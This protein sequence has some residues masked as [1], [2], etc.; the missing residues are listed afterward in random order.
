MLEKLLKSLGADADTISKI[1]AEKPEYDPEKVAG[2][3][4]ANLRKAM[5][6]DT[7]FIDPLRQ[8]WQGEVLSS[9]ERQLVKLSGGK[10]TQEELDALPTTDRFNKAIELLITKVKGS[11]A[12]T[13]KSIKD[14]DEEIAKL[15]SDLSERDLKIKD[16]AEVKLPAAQKE[17]E[18][19]VE[20][21]N[22]ERYVE[23]SLTKKAERKL[24]LDVERTRKLVMD[25]LN[26]RYDV[27]KQDG[28]YVLKQKGKDLLV[29][30]SKDKSKALGLDDAIEN[31]ATEA[32]LFVLN[33]GKPEGEKVTTTEGGGEK[34]VR[35]KRLPG[36]KKARAEAGIE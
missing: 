19:V 23:S 8:K 5:E 32:K 16:L 14:K 31:I 2:K 27:V 30:D 13:S 12:E 25:D 20:R 33:G 35:Y 1:T 34:E 29:Y 6:N 18:R 9:K 36:L 10:L 15:R 28:G 26:S 7:E 3:M 21:F 22:L 11:A 17:A 4:L 24:L